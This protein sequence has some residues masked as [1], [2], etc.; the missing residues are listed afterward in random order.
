M[1]PKTGYK[2]YISS[3][4]KLYS[5]FSFVYYIVLK[6]VAFLKM[7]S[8]ADTRNIVATMQRS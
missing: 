7:S 5:Y 3:T 1:V 4:E 8:V 6:T 2:I